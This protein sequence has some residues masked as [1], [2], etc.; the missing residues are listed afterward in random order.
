[1]K[2]QLE[3]SSK[4]KYKFSNIQGIENLSTGPLQSNFRSCTDPLCC[5]IFL[6]IMIYFIGVSCSA[7]FIGDVNLIGA[8]Y[9]PDHRA[10]GVDTEAVDYPY[11]YFVTPNI[12]E[13]GNYL[14]RT[15][16][17]MECP[18]GITNVYTTN[19]RCLTNNVVTSC[20]FKASPQNA[21]VL[22]Y[23]TV[24]CN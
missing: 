7:I 21:S 18:T 24:P 2:E 13:T 10:C 9:D 1:M 17:L 14:Y 23:N 11:I 12:D 5:F 15:V 20:S 19:L 8:P 3:D 22:F 16:C 6:M 4:P